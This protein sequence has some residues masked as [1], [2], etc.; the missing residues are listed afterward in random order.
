MR[1]LPLSLI[2][3]CLT[4]AVLLCTGCG[5]PNQANIELR[6]QN[7]E[8]QERLGQLQRQ[9]DTDANQI[10]GLQSRI[11]TEPTLP[12]DELAKLYTTHGIKFGRLTG[13]FPIDATKPGDQ[14]LKVYVIPFDQSGQQLKA[15]GTITIEAF[16]LAAK[17]PR[18]GKWEFDLEAAKA[19]WYGEFLLD[20]YYAVVCP[21]QTMPEHPDI[22]IKATFVDELTKL[23]FT[24][25]KVVHVALQP[26]T[27]TQPA[28]Q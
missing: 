1:V 4:S 15:A 5:T 14:G 25:Q 10:A 12:V 6:K 3:T 18:L 16:D 24:T 28:A 27:T 2:L 26:V 7:Q 21:W 9:H 11:P 13:G 17:D 22:T 23:P 8:L 19:N 20:Y